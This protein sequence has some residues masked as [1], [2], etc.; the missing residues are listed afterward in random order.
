MLANPMST[1]SKRH[2]SKYGSAQ[3][4]A[5][6][7]DAA[8]K[9]A[10]GPAAPAPSAESETPTKA[11]NPVGKV[12]AG[13]T[14][15]GG[16][17]AM[18]D[19]IAERYDMVNRVMTFGID[20]SWRKMAVEALQAQPGARILDVATG[21]GDLA[22]LAARRIA[23]STVVGVDASH[24]MLQIGNKKVAQQGLQS[25][26]ELRFGDACALEIPDQFVDGVLIGFG[27]R[28]VPDRA[29][30][31]REI[32]RVLKPGARVCILE[33]TEP[34]E[35]HWLAAAARFHLR[36]LVPRIGALLARAPEYRYLQ[37]SVKAFPPPRRFGE[38]MESSGLQ[39]QQIRPLL[40]GVAHLFVAAPH[41]AA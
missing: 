26:V 8:Q 21:T 16:S 17:G 36:V 38:I 24:G 37:E 35:D 31:L 7:A 39:V 6:L 22:I 12:M 40:F 18:F 10:A 19:A 20:R 2:T 28:N 4:D 32:A 15:V 41:A 3:I 11:A 30:A 27:I 25:R 5:M 34:T 9:N 33:A 13:S 1:R 29:K 14:V 23:H